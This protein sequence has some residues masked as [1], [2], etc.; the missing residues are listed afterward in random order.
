MDPKVMLIFIMLFPLLGSFIGYI[1]GRKNEKYRDS[2]NILITGIIFIVVILLFPHVKQDTLEVSIPYVMGT[3]LH[4]K[5]NAFRYI[6]VFITAFVWLLTTIYSNEYLIKYKN[7]NRYYLFFMLTLWSTIGIF[8]SENF[9]NLFTFFEIMSLTSY[10]LVI[11]EENEYSHE[12]GYTYIVMA[13]TGGL[14]LL[15]GLFLLYDYTN[16][17]D[18]D[19]LQWAVQGIGN[20]KYFIVSLIIIG[21]GVKAS[22]FP[23][24][25]WLPKAYPAA[26]APASAVLS[27]ILVKTGIFGIIVTIEI[28]MKRDL[29]V[30]AVVLILG[31][32]NMLLGGFL[33]LFQRNIKRI[34]AYSSMS[35]VGYILVGIGLMGLLKESGAAALYGTL[36]HVVN[37]AFFKGLLFMLSGIIYISLNTVNINKIRGFGRNK[38]ILKILFIIG[39]F[40]IIGMPGFN[41]FISKNLLHHALAEAEHI[42]GGALF[43]LAEIAFTLSSSFTVAYMLKIFIAVFVEKSEK[44]IE[45]HKINISFRSIIPMGIL[46]AAIIFIGI[47]PNSIMGILEASTVSFGM[48]PMEVDFYNLTNIKSSFIAIAI[49]TVIYMYFIIRYLRKSTNEEWYYENVSLNWFSIENNLYKPLGRMLFKTSYVFLNSIDK[50]L[51]KGVV[52]LEN[53]MRFIGNIELKN[54]NAIKNKLKSSNVFSWKEEKSGNYSIQGNMKEN[55][56]AFQSINE[57]LGDLSRNL[58]SITYSVFLFGTVLLVCLVIMFI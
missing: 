7:R 18:I 53:A 25:I 45:E 52:L 9:I 42:Y 40:A 33:A 27:A 21:F 16:T 1:L 58:N 50:G 51:V 5:L 17:L 41:G 56:E 11:H 57:K 32:I 23:L 43:T 36:Y 34:L 48:K 46:G 37:H 14:I 2:F 8:L 55:L 13:V 24:H 6:F 3:G 39:F 19:A 26:P 29:I 4:L 38:K 15:M 12:A 31:F 44:D 35:Q 20:I 54:R 10:V 28:M 49:G 30:A 47:N 22:M